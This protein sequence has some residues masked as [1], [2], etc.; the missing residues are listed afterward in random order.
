MAE[1]LVKELTHRLLAR[2]G[3]DDSMIEPVAEELAELRGELG[4]S[5]SVSIVWALEQ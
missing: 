5:A 3:A 1:P 4:L 2:V